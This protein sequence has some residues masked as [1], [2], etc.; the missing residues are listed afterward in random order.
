M[1]LL[2]FSGTT[3]F[4]YEKGEAAKSSTAATNPYRLSSRLASGMNGL[5][6]WSGIS[7]DSPAGRFFGAIADREFIIIGLQYGKIIAANR[8]VALEYTCD[9][10][11]V[12][13]V[14]KNPRNEIVTFRTPNGDSFSVARIRRTSVYGV[15]LAPVGWRFYAWQSKPVRL[16]LSVS[17]GFL[18]F[19]DEVPLPDARKFNFTF[20][21]G[22]GVQLLSRSRWAVTLGYKL[23]HLSN[24]NTAPVNPGLDAN[25]FYLGISSFR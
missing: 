22:G 15:G 4:G 1:G 13:M 9:F 20:D 3:G 6:F 24:A 14:T 5:T 19:L 16:F 10:I 18:T 25:I 17:A 21:F 23:H 2:C 11:P 7:F 12:A 8:F